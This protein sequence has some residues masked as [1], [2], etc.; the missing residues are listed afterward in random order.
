MDASSRKGLGFF[1]PRQEEGHAPEGEQNAK[2]L[3]RLDDDH[4]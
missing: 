4:S 2:E 1:G 3:L